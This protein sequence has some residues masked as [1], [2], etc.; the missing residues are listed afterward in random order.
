MEVK[1]P[2]YQCPECGSYA[3]IT[4][5]DGKCYCKVCNNVDEKSEFKQ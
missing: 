3:V 5:V 2:K 4:R 1:K